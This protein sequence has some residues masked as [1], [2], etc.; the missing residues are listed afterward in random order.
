VSGAGSTCWEMCLLQLPMVL[1]DL[2]DNQKPIAGA[3]K[4][5]SAAI[6]LGAA[7]SV[8]VDEIAKRV[9]N[10]LAS[11][12]ERSALSERC[13]RLVDGRGAERVL[14]ELRAPEKIV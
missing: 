12:A 5:I 9:E 14:G 13:G 10:L 3:L 8:T 4:R 2:A 11:A 1:I 6:H 7:G